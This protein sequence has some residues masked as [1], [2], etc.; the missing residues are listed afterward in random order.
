MNALHDSEKG[1]MASRKTDINLFSE[2]LW[3]SFIDVVE[4]SEKIDT[5]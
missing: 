1:T 3:C 2:M 5:V 4:F